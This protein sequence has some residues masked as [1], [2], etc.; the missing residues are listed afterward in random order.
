MDEGDILKGTHYLV[1]R[2]LSVQAEYETNYSQDSTVLKELLLS[3]INTSNIDMV[4]QV[5]KEAEKIKGLESIFHHD[6]EVLKLYIASTITLL[7]DA[8]I[9]QGLSKDMA[10]NCKKKFYILIANCTNKDKLESYYFK[11][12]EELILTL[13]KF[14]MKKYSP[15]VRSAI[16]YINNH[17]LKFIYSKDVAS[18]IGVD[19]SYL[20]KIFSSETGQTITDYIHSV[21]MN[22]ALRLMESNYY[23]LQE[24]SEL[25]GYR[26]YSYFSKLFKKIYL[27]S[28]SEYRSR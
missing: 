17:K 15:I 12:A 22:F 7:V 16:E 28:P 20:S 6:L 5:A 9:K 26:N 14:S 25:L 8:A 27:K 3:A 19:R 23:N 21:K 24:I 4:Y 1:Q 18:E 10:E 13:K 11:C 2:E